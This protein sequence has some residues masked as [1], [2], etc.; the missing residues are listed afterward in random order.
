MKVIVLYDLHF[1][2]DAIGRLEPLQRAHLAF[3]TGAPLFD[4]FC[5][6]TTQPIDNRQHEILF[7]P[8]PANMRIVRCFTT[9]MPV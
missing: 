4:D 6:V 5:A 3:Y 2:G 8:S 7:Y 9:A 1:F